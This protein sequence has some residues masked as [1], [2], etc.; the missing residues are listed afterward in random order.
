M[1]AARGGAPAGGNGGPAAPDAPHAETA[2]DVLTGLQADPRTGLST[3]EAERRL[4]EWGRNELVLER[5]RSAWQ[6]LL[7]QVK[8]TV[9]VLLLAAVVAGLLIGTYVEAAAVGVVLVVN[10]IVGFVTEI[11]AVRSM[12]ALRGLT[13]ST[14]D[15]ERDDRRDEVDATG[16]VPGDLV[17]V[18]GATVC[19]PTSGWSRPRTWRP[20][21]PR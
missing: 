21:R 10:T 5:S 13:S 18:E 20:S 14:A 8:S 2:D 1:T 17:A 16:L 15:V 11:R 7:A 6:I 9:V 19:P 12:E 3:Q 4:Q